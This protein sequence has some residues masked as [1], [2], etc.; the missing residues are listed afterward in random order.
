MFF[1]KSFAQQDFLAIRQLM[2]DF[3]LATMVYT[4]EVGLE[5]NH[6]PLIWQD[7]GSKLGCLFGHFAKANPI[8]QNNHKDKDWLIIFQDNGHYISPNWYPSKA[9]THKEVPTWNYRAVH[10]TGSMQ[11]IDNKEQIKQ[12]LALLTAIYEPTVHQAGDNVW[13]LDDAPVDYI[14]KLCEALI[15][16]KISIKTMQAKFKLSQNKSAENV[17]GVIHG[18]QAVQRPTA[19]QMADLIEKFSKTG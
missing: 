15:M 10:L 6:I 7:D 3:P 5:A 14:D 2:E 17:Q 12:I 13:T 11:I 18:L 1:V 4:S 19:N 9:I 8:W 16:F